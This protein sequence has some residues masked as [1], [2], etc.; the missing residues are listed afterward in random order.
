LL[1]VFVAETTI[2]SDR[3]ELFNTTIV[4]THCRLRQPRN[5]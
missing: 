3:F 1:G 5:L 2:K 4:L